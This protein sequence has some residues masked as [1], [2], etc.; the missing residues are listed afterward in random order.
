MDTNSHPARRRYGKQ[1]QIRITPGS[2]NATKLTQSIITPSQ[3]STPPLYHHV[4]N[5]TQT[6]LQHH[7]STP[8]TPN[9]RIIPPVGTKDPRTTHTMHTPPSHPNPP[10][11]KPH[12]TINSPNTYTHIPSSTHAYHLLRRS[13]PP[14]TTKCK[15]RP[16]FTPNSNTP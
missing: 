8:P 7:P 9:S 4:T 16:R 5:S 1:C 6:P 11:P 3:H 10:P 14:D 13:T 15:F 2:S 12:Q